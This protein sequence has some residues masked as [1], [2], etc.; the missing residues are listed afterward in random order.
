MEE[1]EVVHVF[2]FVLEIISK[3]KAWEETAILKIITFF[4]LVEQ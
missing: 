3:G 4:F 1:I 2:Y